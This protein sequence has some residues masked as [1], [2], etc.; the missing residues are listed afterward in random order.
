MDQPIFF[1]PDELAL[2][3][4]TR[5]FPTKAIITDKLKRTLRQLHEALKEEIAGTRFLTPEGVDFE[6]GQFVRGEHLLD[7]PYQ[8]LD[9]PKLYT[10][11]EKFAFRS[12][13]WWGHHFIFAWI[14]EGKYLSRYKENLLSAYDQLADQGLYV[15][16][17]ETPW[18]W[19]KDPLYLLEIR[20]DNKENVAAALAS[21]PF[22]KIHR[23]IEFDGVELEKGRIVERGRQ[24]FRLM[25]AI[26]T[27]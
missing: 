4:D 14:L 6:V 26:V 12:L 13:F 1:T 9:F 10:N 23:F 3:R 25:R 8:Y 17:T 21:R 7:F 27:D 2:I 20:K 16:M 5:F 18:E 15:L 24:T 11:A 22:L 19:R